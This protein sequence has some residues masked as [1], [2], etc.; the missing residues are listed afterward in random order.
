MGVITKI[1]L[2]NRNIL[3]YFA[4][5]KTSETIT[6]NT[7]NSMSNK[8]LLGIVLLLSASGIGRAQHFEWVRGFAPGENVAIVG[9]VVDSVGNLYILGSINFNTRWEDSIR[10]L[11]VTPRGYAQDGGDVLIAKISPDGDLV[12]HKVIHGNSYSGYPH[13][14]K[15]LGDTAFACLVT[16]PLSDRTNYLYYLDTMIYEST[17]GWDHNSPFTDLPFPDYPISSER[18]MAGHCLALITL[19]FDGHLLEHHFLQ[20]SYMDNNGDDIERY[21]PAPYNETWLYAALAFHYPSFAIDSEGNI[22]LSH[23]THH[24]VSMGPYHPDEFYTVEDGTLG[25]V[26]LWCDRRIVGVITTTDSNLAFS[27]QILKFSPHFDTLLRSRYVFQKG[28]DSEDRFYSNY[29]NTDDRGNL[30]LVGYIENGNRQIEQR[31]LVIDTIRNDYL[32]I[33]DFSTWKGFLIKYDTMINVLSVISL[34][35]SILMHNG[36]FSNNEF[37][38]IAFDYDSNLLFLSAA[39]GRTLYGDTTNFR[40]L[41]FCQ[42]VPLL[43]LKNDV[44][45][46]SFKMENDTLGLYSYG[47]VDANISSDYMQSPLHEHG[48]L[49]AQ[50]GRVFLQSVN[51]GGVRFPNQVFEFQQWYDESPGLTIFDYKGLGIAGQHYN[52]FGVSNNVGPLSIVDSI[53][54]LTSRLASDATFGDIYVPSRGEF[55]AC[56]AKYVDPAFMEPYYTKPTEG[57]V[58]AEA[59]PIAV[60]PNPASGRVHAVLPAEEPLADAFAYTLTGLRHRVPVEGNVL[61]LTGLPS[62][63][64][65]LQLHSSSGIYTQKIIKL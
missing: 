26:K 12:W 42:G 1:N 49:S 54:Y 50:N 13:D 53:L 15:P 57:I 25:G 33:N 6:N 35:D 61:D 47:R 63:I 65:I 29:L 40:T 21:L 17:W 24:M 9:S 31:R 59:S 2:Q 3:R 46:L 43:K 52:A 5:T 20:M 55:F 4:A 48:N 11:P 19:D 39:T 62:G 51:S 34:E 28:P 58:S 38:D 64:L 8:I 16:M 41:L 23:S 60:Y 7:H 10:L 44:F 22:Y 14:I 56:I 37:Y 36:A 45:F 27:P 30:Y 18:I 32:K